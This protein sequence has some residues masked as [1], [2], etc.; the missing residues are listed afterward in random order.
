MLQMGRVVAPHAIDL[1]RTPIVPVAQSSDE[2]KTSSDV[3]KPAGA[4]IRSGIFNLANTILGAGM[5]GLPYAFAECGLVAGLL[6]LLTFACLSAL[7]LHL[8]SAAADL[9]GR[10]ATLYA[11]AHRALAGSGLAIDV[12]VAIKCFGVA[13]SYLIVVGDSLPKALQPFGASGAL[14]DRR[15]WSGL[16]AVVVSPLVFLRR[17]DALR[18]TSLA[19]LLCVL[20][21]T[22]LVLAFSSRPP[23]SAA[24]DPCQG[25]NASECRGPVVA[26]T[27]GLAVLHAL[28]IFTF[29]FTCHQNVI[30][31]SN[32][33]AQPTQ[34]RVGAV[35]LG[36]ETLAL[37]E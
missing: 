18:H 4:S 30:S 23:L 33:L 9:A 5:L 3:R 20:V 19:A 25:R 14:L 6:L 31:I 12:A 27:D 16:A 35:I 22:L 29:A 8:L 34:A 32:E 2:G 11:V 21:I 17:V 10:P 13:T 15:L 37:A 24:L 7:G 36:A 1:Q 28:P 26:I